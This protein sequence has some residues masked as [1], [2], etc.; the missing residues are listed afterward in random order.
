MAG[1]HLE[2]CTLTRYAVAR[3]AFFHDTRIEVDVF[4]LALMLVGVAGL[5]FFAGSGALGRGAAATVVDAAAGAGAALAAVAGT[6]R[7]TAS[8]AAMVRA[9]RRWVGAVGRGAVRTGTGP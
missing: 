2:E 1:P 8:A 3:A 6:T 5:I 9:V 4:P 7:L